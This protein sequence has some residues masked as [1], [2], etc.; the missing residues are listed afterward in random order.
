VATSGS[1]DVSGVAIGFDTQLSDRVRGRMVY[2]RTAG[3]WFSTHGRRRLAS[4]APSLVRTGRELGHDFATAIDATVPGVD[5]EVSLGYR[6]NNL[7]SKAS[8][9]RDQRFD[10]GRFSLDIRQQLPYRPL[11][12]GEFNIVV[13]ARTLLRDAGQDGSFYDEL[14][15]MAPPMQVTCGIQMRF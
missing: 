7:F 5:T 10:R 4:A 14:M 8:G 2:T 15:T 9:E 13:S 3:E 6:F 1:V 11:G 12:Q